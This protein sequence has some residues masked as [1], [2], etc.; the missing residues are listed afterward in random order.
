MRVF[1]LTQTE[2]NTE[3]V[4]QVEI[5]TKARSGHVL[6]DH[7]DLD[8]LLVYMVNIGASDLHLTVGTSPV[9]RV[10]GK[11][12]RVDT[13]AKN[14]S[15][16]VRAETK[17]LLSMGDFGELS[18]ERIKN[19]IST[20]VGDISKL[21]S[22]RSLD[23]AYSIPG[24]SRYR[25]NVFH[26]QKALAVACRAL[27]ESV[28]GLENLFPG[29]VNGLIN[30]AKLPRGLVLVTG[31]TGSGK[32]TTLAAMVDYIN[33]NFERHIIT[34]EDPIE[35]VHHH[36]KSIVNQREIGQDVLSFA[37]GLRDALR[38]D[39]DVILV[40][41][42]RDLE[43]ISTGVTAAETGH[44]VLSSLHTNDA[45]QTV[46]RIVDVFPPHQQQ[47]I[48]VQLASVLKGVVSQQLLPRSDGKGRVPAIELMVVNS[49][50]SA[51]IQENKL[52]QI[53]SQIQTGAKDNM[54]LL[55]KSL[56]ELVKNGLVSMDEARSR[57]VNPNTFAEYVR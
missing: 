49:G 57:A 31:P 21:E 10:N 9:V 36:N 3:M 54:V 17:N 50:I 33:Q 51:L 52:P 34:L 56:A 40:G 16:E 22:N 6:D 5:K 32:S 12:W 43:T 47:Q 35:Y 55:D 8:K 53:S 14:G 38:E 37:G 4:E 30:L 29:Q 2:A 19:L 25:V 18:A 26:Q 13:L 24:V 44:L 15:P 20:M 39:P 48:R 7:D 23:L 27:S 28:N 42:L 45:A 1:D 41:E 46:A 11:L